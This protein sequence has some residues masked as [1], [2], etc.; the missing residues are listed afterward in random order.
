MVWKTHIQQYQ[1]ITQNSHLHS[2]QTSLKFLPIRV[3]HYQCQRMQGRIRD[4][5]EV[6]RE[7]EIGQHNSE[8]NY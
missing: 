8:D 4:K 1:W 7:R 6:L 2:F 5:H 3:A